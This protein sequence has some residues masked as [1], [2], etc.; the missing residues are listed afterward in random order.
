MSQ[1]SITRKLTQTTAEMDAKGGLLFQ[2]GARILNLGILV[3]APIDAINHVAIG[4]FK[5]AK[6]SF[7]F[8]CTHFLK[9]A[10]KKISEI[11]EDD[12][13]LSHFTD[14]IKH[15]A[16]FIL[17]PVGI[18]SPQYMNK[19]CESFFSELPKAKHPLEE[20]PPSVPVEVALPKPSPT[21]TEKFPPEPQS[22][23]NSMPRAPS[24]PKLKLPT[25]SYH[26]EKIYSNIVNP[27]LNNPNTIVPS[28]NNNIQKNKFYEE[29]K[30]QIINQ[31]SPLLLE[32][33]RNIAKIIYNEAVKDPICDPYLNPRIINKVGTV[34]LKLIANFANKTFI[35]QTDKLLGKGTYKEAY[36]G[37]KFTLNPDTENLLKITIAAVAVLRVKLS[38]PN[39]MRENDLAETFNSK[40]IIKKCEL[41]FEDGNDW[42][43]VS[44]KLPFFFSEIPLQAEIKP[45]PSFETVS[46]KKAY[47]F[48][49]LI[50]G[51]KGAA[52][53]L[54]EIHQKKYM[55]RDIKP[56]NMAIKDNGKGVVVDLGYTIKQNVLHGRSSTAYYTP[57]ELVD[58]KNEWKKN[59][60]T[61]QG[62]LWAFGISLFR[63]FHPNSKFPYQ[64]E[65]REEI[66]A[67]LNI[68]KSNPIEFESHLFD[69]WQPRNAAESQLQMLIAK[70][71]SVD[72]SKR[73][74]ALEAAAE[75]KAIQHLA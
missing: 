42:I 71:L 58:N 19:L 21:V 72:S 60:Q 1:V 73:G 65:N 17:T 18:V 10:N 4:V 34:G 8:C 44:E 20:L 48:N 39:A 67:K 7:D 70:L 16:L 36:E 11:V 64:A 41:T 13:A 28:I 40:H 75:L 55:H 33:A 49:Q 43:M 35:I 47:S 24:I 25:K 54:A 56:A 38:I 61:V 3:S 26:E 51:L 6:N 12:A 32:Y 45:L 22:K 52:K 27:A 15:I 50:R 66:R 31:N 30:A 68:I 23:I 46:P 5:A 57:P 74:T 9:L 63:I 59:S 29:C 69:S 14:A 53:G 37:F 2:T 62:D